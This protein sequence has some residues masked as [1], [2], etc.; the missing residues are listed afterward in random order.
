MNIFNTYKRTRFFLWINI[1]GLA[2]GLAAAIMLILFVVNEL[3]YDRHFAN[4]ERIVRLM[5]VYER[6][7]YRNY[8]VINIRKAYTEL[9]AK[10]PGVEAAIQL[11]YKGAQVEV[12]AEQKR[13]SMHSMLADAEFFKVFQTKFI[14]G[15]PESCLSLPNAAV[16]TRKWADIMFGSPEDA[17]GKTISFDG[18]DFVVTAVVEAFPKNSHLTFD[19]LAPITTIPWLNEAGGLEFFTYYL[20]RE[21]VSVE[22]TR[23]AI[24]DE[25]RTLLKPW[26][27]A[28]GDPEAHGTT[29]MLDDVYLKSKVI[30][31]PTKSGSMPFIWVL[32]GLAL[33]ILTL[34]VT[35]FINLF[36]TQGQRRMSEVGVRKANGAQ[37][38]DIVR[39]FFSEIA[40]IVLVA[41]AVGLVL[42]VVCVPYFADLIGRDVDLAQLANPMFIGAA[43]LLFVATVVFSAFYPAFYLS[44]FSP[45]EILGKR[46]K[47][48]KR[49]LTASVVVFQSVISIVLLSVIVTLYKQTAYLE[50]LPLGYNPKN[51]M[52]VQCNGALSNNYEAIKQELQKHPEVKAVGGSHHVFG[53]G[54][55]GQ[56]ITKW[57]EQ[58]KRYPINEYRLMSGMPELMDLKL[59]EGRFWREDDP[60]SVRTLILNEAAVKML[61]GESPLE[62]TYG[63][64][65]RQTR[66][67]G[68]VKDFY[69][70]NPV[71]N[72]EPIV[73]SRV[74]G[75]SVVNIRFAE[76]VSPTR[77]REVAL[78]VFRQ[79]DPEFVL[80]PWWGADIYASKFRELK[81]VTRMVLIGS[82][83]AIFVAML[84]LL[85]IHLFTAMRRT[86]E[87][88][89]R[90]V[91][92]AG[93]T[94]IFVLL[95]LDI[96]KW[97]GYAAVVAIPVAAY[98]IIRILNTYANHASPDWMVFVLPVLAQ[99]LIALLTTSGVTLN[100]LRR[101]PA[102]TIKTE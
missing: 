28:V 73:L 3:S 68:V 69:Y 30:H 18:K 96:L 24:E 52:L 82:L 20:I 98:C 60:D 51:L 7:D 65:Q 15:V 71:L 80:N 33:F 49:R 70:N 94:S 72:I 4:R 21:S 53:G 76:G 38:G 59:T 32:T 97:I 57:E 44:R 41:F 29:E 61:G 19:I 16:I 56:V 50:K 84:G 46:V 62:K 10:A 9:P 11:Y 12:I 81:M 100:A 48:S 27:Q 34:A 85:A 91:H 77:A 101:N 25:Y 8:A 5:T 17:A 66:V 63:Y 47:L 93:R 54:W 37:I 78:D 92:G 39:Q 88:G 23:A 6:N 58:D 31:S 89:I 13:F 102:E 42:A 75:P 74:F 26:A 43:A 79:F 99:C 87:I 83:A 67:I 22:D 86:K 64:H 14:E 35:N 40:M 90:R 45:L 95:S 36:V 2:L 1:T 55:S